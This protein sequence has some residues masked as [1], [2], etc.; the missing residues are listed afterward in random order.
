MTR[1]PSPPLRP[2]LAPLL[3][4]V[5]VVVGLVAPAAAQGKKVDA[6]LHTRV[7][8]G[9]I[10]LALVLDIAASWHLYHHELGDPNA[11]GK[12]TVIEL[13]APGVSWSAFTWPE[14]ERA[15]QV[16]LGMGGPDPTILQHEGTL[17]VFATGTPGPGVDAEAAARSVVANV[18]GLTCSEITGLCVPYRAE[19]D[20]A[21]DAQA[22]VWSRFPTAASA[23]TGA[24]ASSGASTKSAL[25]EDAWVSEGHARAALFSDG[26]DERIR[27]AIVIDIEDHWHLYHDELGPK[28]ATG[29]P[30]TVE[31][32]AEN[33]T[34]E[35]VRFPEP[36]RYEQLGVGAVDPATGKPRDT[37]IQGHQG[38]FVLTVE[39]DVAAGEAP[40]LLTAR[41]AGLTCRDGDGGECIPWSVEL[42]EAGP[43]PAGWLDEVF[44]AAAAS[45]AEGATAVAVPP[46]VEG[47]SGGEDLSLLAFLLLAVGGGLFTLMMPCT[48]PMIPI[49]ISFFT[50]QAD[51]RDG[52]V[53]PLALAYGVG[54]VL[55]FV[56]IGVL[57]GG[58]IQQFAAHPITNLLIG[59]LFTLFG[60]S[61]FGLVNL[62]PPAFLMSAAGKASMRGGYFGVFLMGATLVVTSFTCTAPIVGSLLPLGAAGEDSDLL[63]VTLGMGVF[64]LTMAVPFVLLSLLPGR[65]KAMPQ[66][67][68]WM[69]VLKVTL[70]FV[71]LAAALKFFSNS[72]LGWNWGFLSREVFL[73]AWTGIF[74][75][76]AM[77]L[78]G[79]ID[80]K[81]ET[82]GAIGPGRLVAGL[83]FVLLG[84]YSFGGMLG[85]RLDGIMVA[86]VPPYSSWSD[87]I[88]TLHGGQGTPEHERPILLDDYEGALELAR[89]ENKS[90]LV[91]FTGFTCVNCRKMELSTFRAPAVA[92][93]LASDFVEVRVHYD[94]PEKAMIKRS[95]ELRSQLVEGSTAA[96]VYVVLD[97]STQRLRARHDGFATEAEFLEFLAAGLP[98]R[99]GP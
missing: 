27:A 44:R 4:L 23:G 69:N 98:A 24:R 75:V 97:P 51:Q 33:V 28:D 36:V 35:R 45:R 7:V 20:A 25:P 85:L 59:M 73:L 8:E 86:F 1:A 96:P 58:V 79:K 82:G 56:A 16:G 5:A 29:L 42:E 39:G 31:L 30:T 9:R 49:T 70:G 95:D 3:A 38:R 17:E 6:S 71:E 93:T 72:D 67:G 43:G 81:G 11:A 32:E 57:V 87:G 19:V 15:V 14:P 84:L 12:P 21:L 18:S 22:E 52:K 80:L 91:N 78:F 99:T 74:L 13:D 37:W 54:I 26:D 77:F 46:R 48:Y 40:G 63:R 65:V 94:H 64:G 76:C 83:C 90:V 68:Q 53:L 89:A 50:K 62:Q 10:Q 41:V 66:S 47:T 61:L 2:R 60:L 55:T 92:E 34:W 88:G